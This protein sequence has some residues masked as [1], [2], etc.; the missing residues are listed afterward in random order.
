LEINQ[1]LELVSLTGHI[2]P[3]EN[4]EPNVHA[5]FS[6]STVSGDTVI[7]LGGHLTEGT[8][9]SIKVAVAIAVIEDI[10]MKSVFR[11]QSKSDEL[12]IE[13]HGH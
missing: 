6:A 1:P 4:G 9:T 3:K 7:T 13:E 2:S 10:P 5:H 11:L 12:V 8:I